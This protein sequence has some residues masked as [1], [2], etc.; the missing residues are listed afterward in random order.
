MKKLISITIL[1]IILFFINIILVFYMINYPEKPN[2]I[3]AI[4]CSFDLKVLSIF[5]FTILL[6]SIVGSIFLYKKINFTRKFLI[7][8]L[9]FN[10]AAILA[11]TI[12]GIYIFSINKEELNNL[13]LM[14]RNNALNDIKKDDVKTFNHGLEL[15][16][17]DKE[18]FNV[19]KKKDSILKKYGLSSRSNCTISENLN[20]VEKEYEK[21]TDPYLDKRNGKFWRE[22]MEREIDNIKNHK[23]KTNEPFITHTKKKCNSES[24]GR[25]TGAK[26]R[27]YLTLKWN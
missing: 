7:L 5:Y 2:L 18:A 3:N 24:N 20:I 1:S 14:Y 17:K 21:I 16:P 4:Q 10:S 11:N 19:Y 12:N 13:I 8:I 27:S 22:K 9:F 15:P 26:T 6:I 25:F 23:P